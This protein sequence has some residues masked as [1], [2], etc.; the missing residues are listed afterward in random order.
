MKKIL[1]LVAALMLVACPVFAQGGGGGFGAGSGGGGGIDVTTGNGGGGSIVCVQT[2][3]WGLA[4]LANQVAVSPDGTVLAA[5]SADLFMA[6]GGMGSSEESSTW[7]V[8][9]NTG[10]IYQ[11]AGSSSHSGGGGEILAVSIPTLG[12]TA[13]GNSTSGFAKAWGQGWG[14]GSAGGGGGGEIGGG[15]GFGFGD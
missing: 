8:N 14:E 6:E 3:S 4:G 7:A 13:G 12:I 11:S 10:T 9:P 1:F 2:A 15:M 5:G